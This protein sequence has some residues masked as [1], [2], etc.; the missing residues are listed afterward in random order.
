MHCAQGGGM[1]LGGVDTLYSG[2]GGGI[3]EGKMT[4]IQ[5]GGCFFGGGGTFQLERMPGILGGGGIVWG[6]VN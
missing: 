1:Y 4:C 6:R 2:G 5:G 3:Q